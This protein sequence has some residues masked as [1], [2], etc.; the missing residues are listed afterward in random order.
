VAGSL[1]FASILSPGQ[2]GAF[3]I[4]T[5]QNVWTVA[6]D[7]FAQQSVLLAGGQVFAA[8]V[9]SLFALDPSTGRV[10]WN[11]LPY[12]GSRE[13]FYSPP[14]HR[15]GRIY[16]GDRHGIIHCLDVK[17]GALVWWYEPRYAHHRNMIT[18]PLVYRD[19]LI[20]A[21]ARNLVVAVDLE[22]G[23]ELWRTRV[24]RHP[25]KDI[26]EQGGRVLIC[27]TQSCYSLD[28]ESG[29]VV[30]RATWTRG[31]ISPFAV[32]DLYRFFLSTIVDPAVQKRVAV[33]KDIEPMKD[34]WPDGMFDNR[35]TIPATHDDQLYF[36]SSHYRLIAA[37]NPA[38]G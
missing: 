21:V 19:R 1:V 20:T 24:A 16:W 33:I 13:P 34:G 38:V 27:T 26:C 17:T 8:S 5:G 3:E 37:R 28:P 12:P 30:E 6:L 35:T 36:R 11:Y 25:S 9:Q 15:Q 29:A 22:T 32:S 2:I 4:E 10:L 18:T 7:Q 23:Q 31:E 14:V